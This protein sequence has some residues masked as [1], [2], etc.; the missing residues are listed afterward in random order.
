MSTVDVSSHLLNLEP[1]ETITQS[2]MDVF[3]AQPCDF[4]CCR[5]FHHSLLAFR[6][7]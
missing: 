4:Q 7:S 1:S 2:T 3:A 6:R 5:L